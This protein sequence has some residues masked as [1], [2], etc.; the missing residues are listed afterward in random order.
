MTRRPWTTKELAKL[1][2]MRAAGASH[3]QVAEALGRTKHAVKNQYERTTK[4]P[5]ARQNR[6][7]FPEKMRI[8]TLRAE[9]WSSVTIGLAVGRSPR[10]IEKF[11][12][13]TRQRAT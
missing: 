12:A 3:A 11:L 2:E 9:G 13:R 5:L 1:H 7:T 6:L 10:T 4:T 8:L